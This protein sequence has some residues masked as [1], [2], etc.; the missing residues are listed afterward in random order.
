MSYGWY[1]DQ[2]C[3]V[4]GM[5]SKGETDEDYVDRTNTEFQK[6]GTMGITMIASS[7]DDGTEPDRGC[8]EMRPDFPAS[9]VYVLSVGATA[10]VNNGTTYPLGS[11]APPSCS[12]RSCDCSTS[13]YEETAMKTNNAHFDTGGGF[14]QYLPQPSYQTDVVE[15]YLNSGVALPSTQYWNPKNRG[16]PDVT[17]VGAEVLI[18]KNG[19]P[20]KVG[21]T[22]ASCP[23]WGGLISL[24]NADRLNAGKS[25]LGFVNPMFYQLYA[26]QPQAFRDITVGTN[27]GGCDN[28]AF[29]ATTGWDPLSGL[30]SP[31]F[32]KIRAYVA[33]LP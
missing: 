9:S 26:E 15:A 29:Q 31:N 22:S 8:D 28:L 30:G 18:I 4:D 1:E 17:A 14:S 5:C 7:G 23:I 10:V 24:L 16:Y 13:R 19:S 32:D 3:S 11:N 33:T 2:Q 20:I 27:G 6:L 25:P 21:G 12:D